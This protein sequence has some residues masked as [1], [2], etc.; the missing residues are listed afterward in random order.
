MT[1]AD[2][3][4]VAQL[5]QTQFGIEHHKPIRSAALRCKLVICSLVAAEGVMISD[6]GR[7]EKAVPRA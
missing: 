3:A 6:S 1:P 4:D 2:E 7:K 5:S